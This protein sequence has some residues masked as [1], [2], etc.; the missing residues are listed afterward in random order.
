MKIE[1]KSSISQKKTLLFIVFL[2]VFAALLC[3]LIGDLLLP[4]CIALLA[5][6]YTFGKDGK[7]IYGRVATV[8]LIVLNIVT[9]TIGL[10]PSLYGFQAIALAWML[11]GA[12]LRQGSKA[13]NAYLMSIVCS[14]FTVGSFIL[15]AML[16]TGNFTFEGVV[17]YYE[18]IAEVIRE[19]FNKAFTQV[20]PALLEATGFAMDSAEINFVV[21]Y[22]LSMVIA[23]VFIASFIA[24][25]ISMKL[26]GF[27]S[28][29]IAE[30]KTPFEKWRFDTI[31]VFAY[32]YLILS[33]ASI[34]I[35]ANN[36]VMSIAVINLNAIFS[37]IFTYVGYKF[38][39]ELL[40]RRMNHKIAVVA[41][42]VSLVAFSS[43]AFQIVSILGLLVTINRRRYMTPPPQRK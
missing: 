31:P 21:D 38:L 29:R 11:S 5:V 13:D 19:I 34:F 43:F 15:L 3:C 24:V 8:T 1:L 14:I 33:I 28:S 42:L 22:L 39:I 37:V 7:A 18:E 41:V 6:L 40:S 26:F 36:D 10:T 20:D 23:Y 9:I 35:E 30:D 12:F 17:T 16:D 25:G 27:L 32:F 2:L 4:V